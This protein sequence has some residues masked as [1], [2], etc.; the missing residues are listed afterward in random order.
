MGWP[1]TVRL[2]RLNTVPVGEQLMKSFPP[3]KLCYITHI[4]KLQSI[5]DKGIPSHERIKQQGS[6][7]TSIHNRGTVSRRKAKSTATGRSLLDYANLYFQPRNPMMYSLLGA[8]KKENF[9]VISISKD[10][11]HEQGVFITDG[12]AANPLTQFYSLPEGL[13]ILER[14]WKTVQSDWWN[15]DDGSKRKIMAEC[16]VPDNVKPDLIRSIFVAGDKTKDRVMQTV[17]ERQIS[18]E[19][20]PHMFFQPG[21]SIRIGDNISII[22]GDIFFSC[23]QTLTITV[24]LQRVMGKGLALRTK[25]QF[26][27][28]YVKYEDACRQKKI[29]TRRPYLYKRETSFNQELGYPSSPR[30]TPDAVKWFLLFATKEKWRDDTRLD[31][32]ESGLDWVKNNYKK[33][34][35]KSLAL[36][37]LGCGLGTLSWVDVGPL[38]CKYL[39]GME[40]QVEIYLPREQKIDSQYLTKSYL[41]AGEGLLPLQYS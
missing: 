11:L 41:L 4:N 37:A 31:N 32:I 36:P 1:I 5:L 30:S 33:E 27:D 16:L 25:Y 22:D 24:N 18:V 9:V 40:I 10:V 19:T 7:P 17:G 35:I 34:E 26:P 20:E 21:S 15:N 8:K 13:K 39:H 12:D 14:Q 28:V 3:E 23:M 29:R 6:R 2:Q 38:M